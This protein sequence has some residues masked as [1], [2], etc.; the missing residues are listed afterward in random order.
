MLVVR[1]GSGRGRALSW[2]LLLVW[3]GVFVYAVV[4]PLSIEAQLL[5]AACLWMFMPDYEDVLTLLTRRGR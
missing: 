4:T 5:I 1:G 2:L 3:I